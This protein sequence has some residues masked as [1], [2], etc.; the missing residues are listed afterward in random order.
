[1]SEPV[2]IIHG[3]ANHDPAPFKKS[4]D[5]LQAQLGAD[6]RL[7]PVVWGDLGGKSQDISDCLPIYRDG[8]WTTRADALAEWL[9]TPVRADLG[10]GRLSNRE[11][12]ALLT[13]AATEEST[14]VRSGP[15]E[16]EDEIAAALDETRTLQH[17]DDEAVLAGLREAIMGAAGIPAENSVDPEGPVTYRVRDAMTFET[18][19]RITDAVRRVIKGVDEMVGKMLGN[20][21]GV[22]NQRL[23]SGLAVPFSLF[24][25]DILAYQRNQDRIQQ[26]LWDAI[27]AHAP[28]YGTEA[29]PIHVIAHSLGGLVVFD[30]ANRAEGDPKRLFMKSFLTFGSQPAFFHIIDPRPHLDEYKRD[31]KVTLPPTFGKWTNLWDTMDILAFTAST[32]FQLHDGKAPIDIPVQDPLSLILDEKGWTHSIYWRTEELEKA[33]NE[34]LGVGHAAGES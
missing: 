10:Q 7:I 2:L 11:R 16:L 5:T 12:A 17:I 9:P 1:M 21:L 22:T 8:R 28:G 20:N 34:T 14:L 18:R 32:V 33:L 15:S 23:R 25:G 3:V 30:A 4:V 26:R 24:F 31:H 13:G 27:D 29:K 19:D 6:Y